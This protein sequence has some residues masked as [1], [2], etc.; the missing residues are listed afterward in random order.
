MPSITVNAQVDIAAATD[1]VWE[2][3]TDFARYEQRN[4]FMRIE[5]VAEADTN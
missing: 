2:V 3:L 4:P 5:G 1:T